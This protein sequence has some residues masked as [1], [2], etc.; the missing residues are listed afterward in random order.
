VNI[1]KGLDRISLV[2]A[3]LAVFPGFI[4][5]AAFTMET[6]KIETVEYAAYREKLREEKKESGRIS[7]KSLSGRGITI[8]SGLDDRF[9]RSAAPERYEYPPWWHIVLGGVIFAPL[10]FVI[11]LLGTRGLTRGIKRFFWW[12][13]E[14]FKG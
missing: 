11:V 5:G 6:F 14:G 10:S 7:S 1:I 3:I 4:L 12:I 2:L 9:P 13:V 8:P